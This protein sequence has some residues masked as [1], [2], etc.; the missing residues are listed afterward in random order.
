MSFC[1]VT[2]TANKLANLPICLP[3]SWICTVRWHSAASAPKGDRHDT[4]LGL[5]AAGRDGDYSYGYEYPV[6]LLGSLP[7]P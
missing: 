5:A 1:G 3:K 7:C 2:V 4:G 6:D